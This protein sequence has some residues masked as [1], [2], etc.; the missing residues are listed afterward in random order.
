MAFGDDGSHLLARVEQAATQE[1]WQWLKPL[2]AVQTLEQIW[3]Q[4]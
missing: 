1:G 3:A 4:Q 2:P